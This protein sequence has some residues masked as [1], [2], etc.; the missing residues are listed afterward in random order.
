MSDW[1]GHAA[2]CHPNSACPFHDL[3]PGAVGLHRAPS[4]GRDSNHWVL[5]SRLRVEDF[6][7][8]AS[9]EV[10]D[11]RDP[12][13]NQYL[14]PEEDPATQALLPDGTSPFHVWSKSGAEGEEELYRLPQG[15]VLSCIQARVPEPGETPKLELV[16]GDPNSLAS[17]KPVVRRVWELVLRAHNMITLPVSIKDARAM[18]PPAEYWLPGRLNDMREQ[19]ACWSTSEERE[20]E[21][22]VP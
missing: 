15:R 9:Q 7:I 2:G 18:I 8:D 22:G 1:Q 16:S 3:Y 21:S 5:R 12:W 17:G 10:P 19:W 20:G 11:P 6:T 13:P 4:L 14:P